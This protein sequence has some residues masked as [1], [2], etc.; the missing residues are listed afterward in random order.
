MIKGNERR[1]VIIR[2]DKDA[3][4]DM[5]CV[6]IKSERLAD[7]NSEDIV[8]AAEAIISKANI[9]KKE[10]KEKNEPLLGKRSIS[11]FIGM[12]SGCALS[13]A[14]YIFICALFSL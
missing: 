3:I 5:A 14:T 7:E 9:E 10:G 2:G 11:F 13:Y 6:F 12:I 1:V 8:K 4:Y